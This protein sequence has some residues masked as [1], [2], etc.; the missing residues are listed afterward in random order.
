MRIRSRRIPGPALAA[1]LLLALI[2]RTAGAGTELG[3]R[4]GYSDLKGSLFRG[5]DAA[6]GVPLFGV[7]AGFPLLPELSLWLSGEAKSNDVRFADVGSQGES[8]LGKTTWR[9][10]SLAAALHVNLLPSAAGLFSLYV[11]GGGGIHFV[12]LKVQ[13]ITSSNPP[14]GK[15]A[16]PGLRAEAGSDPVGDFLRKLEKQ[17]SDFSWHAVVGASRGLPLIPVNAF[18][19]ARFEDIQGDFS[20]HGY[21]VYAGLNLDLD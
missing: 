15:S 5:S 2:C 8:Y 10:I 20:P 21:S 14:A 4:A 11:G 3:V 19:E 6:G 7:Q 16:A 18:I 1:A 13:Q 17:R 12:D 9:D